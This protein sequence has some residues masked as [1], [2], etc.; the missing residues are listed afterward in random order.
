MT[1]QGR[2]AIYLTQGAKNQN[3]CVFPMKKRILAVNSNPAELQLLRSYLASPGLEWEVLFLENAAA[4]IA[5]LKAG[6]A[7]IILTDFQLSD[8]RGL[9]LLNQ[10]T[11][12]CPKIGTI[13][14][15][16]LE[17]TDSALKCVG[18]AHQ[19]LGKPCDEA[20]LKDSLDR[21]LDSNAWMPDETVRKLARNMTLIPSPPGLY[22][23]II[24]EIQKTDHAMENVGW[25]IARDPATTVRLL[26]MVN[27][28]SFGLSIR[29][30]N[31]IEAV[32]Y[33]GLKMTQSLV[34]MAHTLSFAEHQPTIKPAVDKIWQHSVQVSG[35]AKA[36]ARVERL[37]VS[38]AEEAFTAGLLHDIGQL[39]L[40]A[41]YPDDYAR[42]LKIAK[43]QGIPAEQAEFQVFGTSHA[44]LG[45]YLLATWGLPWSVVEAV[46]LHHKPGPTG[47]HKF[48]TVTILHAAN[49]LAHVIAG[50]SKKPIVDEAYLQS[51]GV[52]D[53]LNMWREICQ[54]FGN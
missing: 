7:D 32:V 48:G 54:D 37:S 18:T 35:F 22:F 30:S 52:A 23:R 13:V 45:A 39:I 4:A 42:T 15:A 19:F 36:I 44:E 26:Q 43:E 51:V 49:A 3:G 28:V 11:T 46:A 24:K 27:S 40:A 25:L 12:I 9:D 2:L 5:S 16:N 14:L 34:L 29:I 8:L 17:T 38:I 20:R 31:P 21:A 33:V 6:P 10:A 47:G 41:N 50:D 53:H 1:G